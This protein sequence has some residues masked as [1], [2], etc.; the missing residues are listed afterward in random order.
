[1]HEL[2]RD[3]RLGLLVFSIFALVGASEVRAQ[4]SDDPCRN[5]N[6]DPELCPPQRDRLR[7][8]FSEEE[9]RGFEERGF[10]DSF[11]SDALNGLSDPLG[12]GSVGGGDLDDGNFRDL[13][14][15]DRGLIPAFDPTDVIIPIPALSTSDCCSD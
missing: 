14:P 1:M 11:L 9:S 12:G 5:P 7:P 15:V 8:T 4:T 3:L 2:R 13:S 10:S 6:A